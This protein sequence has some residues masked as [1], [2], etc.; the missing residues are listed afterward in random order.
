MPDFTHLAVHGSGRADDLAAER[1]SYGLMS[2]TDAQNRC[3]PGHAFDHFEA[4]AGA[5]RIAGPWGD[6][7]TLGRHVSRLA[8]GH[9]IVAADFQLGAQFA[10]EV[11]EV[12]GEAVVVID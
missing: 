12:I 5:V 2:E 7:D 6:D 11:I 3:A 10:E 8:Q 9:R 1:L 4:Y